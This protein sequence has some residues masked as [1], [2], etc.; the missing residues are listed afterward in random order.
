MTI[1]VCS[2]AVMLAPLLAYSRASYGLSVTCSLR[3]TLLP[4]ENIGIG[5]VG[6]DREG[7][8]RDACLGSAPARNLRP[9]VGLDGLTSP[10]Y[11]H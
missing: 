1:P 3:A 6:E 8:T 2:N 10:S 7:V 9:W 5:N 11:I 4:S